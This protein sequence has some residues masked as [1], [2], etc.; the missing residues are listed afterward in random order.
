MTFL[1][2]CAHFAFL[3]GHGWRKTGELVSGADALKY[4]LV[5]E[6]ARDGEAAVA[7][8]IAVADAIAEASPVAVRT[9]TA[10]LRARGAG[11]LEAA[12]E[13]E[14]S[15]QAITYAYDDLREG[16]DAVKNKR[17]PAFDT[18]YVAPSEE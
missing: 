8:A 17:K 14:A 1:I 9:T 13:R 11:N 16:L 5:T 4:G 15:G 7:R 12:L 18:H 2:V 6:L 10:M 3:N